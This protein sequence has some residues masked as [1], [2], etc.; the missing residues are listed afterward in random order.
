MNN[1]TIIIF[2]LLGLAVF[3]LSIYLGIILVRLKNQK[4]Q[5][6][7]LTQDFQDELENRKSQLYESLHTLALVME[8]GQ[9]GIAEGCIRIKKLIDLEDD[10]RFHEDLSDFH[11]AYLDFADLA[12]LEDY[13]KLSNQ[14][15]F[16][17][18][19]KRQK[20]E[21][22]HEK[23]LVQASTKLKNLIAKYR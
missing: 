22:I 23:T 8:Q 7:K 21:Q 16:K 12:F 4:L 1:T 10:L 15:K 5:K 13:K 19:L 6:E 18:D 17:Q 11:K 14:E 2:I 20:F 3:G 9:V